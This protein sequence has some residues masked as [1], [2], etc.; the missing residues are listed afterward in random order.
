M[1]RRQFISLLGGA[2]AS[3]LTARAQEAGRI[4]RLGFLIPSGRDTPA[5][6]AFL[7]E[8]PHK[9]TPPPCRR[10]A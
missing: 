2:A 3:L 10:E 9:A 8:P 6:L 5:L 4:Y 7:D 1:K